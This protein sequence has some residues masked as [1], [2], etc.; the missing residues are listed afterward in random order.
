MTP[1]PVLQ[2]HRLVLACILQ[3]SMTTM[4]KTFENLPLRQ[5]LALEAPR[6]PANLP[7]VADSEDHPSA[8]PVLRV[9]TR[10]AELM[11]LWT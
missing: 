9:H 4:G 5:L 3:V 2:V 8:I 7:R 10:S 1:K 11:I 6:P